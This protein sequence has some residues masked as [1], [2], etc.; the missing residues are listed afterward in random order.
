MMCC[1]GAASWTF[2]ELAVPGTALL[3]F[4]AAG[5]RQSPTHK[6]A[7]RAV[8]GT[9]SGEAH[10]RRRG[11]R[12]PDRAVPLDDLMPA[13]FPCHIGQLIGQPSGGGFGRR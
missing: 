9:A 6:K 13:A 3:R 1:R 8:P 7:N 10:P 2:P 5:R 11:V 12:R 4:A